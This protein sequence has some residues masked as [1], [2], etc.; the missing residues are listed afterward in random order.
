VDKIRKKKVF[1]IQCSRLND[2]VIESVIS[3]DGGCYIKELV[4]GDNGRTS[5][6]IAE[7]MGIK[8]LCKELDVLE[9]KEKPYC[10]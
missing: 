7:I 4:S 2:Y 10:P 3:C 1:S 6:S 5:P 8:A 9:I